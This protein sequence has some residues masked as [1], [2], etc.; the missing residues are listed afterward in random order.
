MFFASFYF[1]TSLLSHNQR[2]SEH[3][4]EA[5]HTAL[6]FLETFLEDQPYVCGEHYTL[7]DLCISTS[8]LAIKTYYTFDQQKY[9][10]IF[11]WMNRMSALHYFWEVNKTGHHNLTEMMQNKIGELDGT[12]K[13]KSFKL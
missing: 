12:R 5:T 4:L 2:I 1:Q 10:R 8:I 6:S 13:K 3:Q 11:H 7:A 9:P